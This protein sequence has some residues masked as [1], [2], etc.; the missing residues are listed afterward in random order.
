M[1]L[2]TV[3]ETVCQGS[4]GKLIQ[5]GGSKDTKFIVTV[6]NIQQYA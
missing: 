6:G 3:A 4:C 2:L 5:Q 1:Q